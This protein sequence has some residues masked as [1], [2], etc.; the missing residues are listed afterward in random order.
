[1]V[2]F[3]DSFTSFPQIAHRARGQGRRPIN[4]SDNQAASRDSC[5]IG[6]N[7]RLTCSRLVSPSRDPIGHLRGQKSLYEI[8][9]SNLP[10]SLDPTGNF[11]IDVKEASC[12][13][14]G[15]G[16][17]YWGFEDGGVNE[18]FLVQRVCT[19]L[20]V[21]ECKMQAGGCCKPDSPRD[22]NSCV[23]EKLPMKDGRGH[24]LWRLPW[25]IPPGSC[26]TLGVGAITA[27]IR[28]F[29]INIEDTDTWQPAGTADFCDILDINVG[30]HR[31]EPPSYWGKSTG[32]YK[33]CMI[34][35]WNCCTK[36]SPI[37]FLVFGTTGSFPE[38]PACGNGTP[39]K[40][41]GQIPW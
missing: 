41:Q 27:E 28:A 37:G 31:T 16:A 22:C 13:G 40:L 39:P 3:A 19:T 5:S 21:A 14:C 34:H 18:W 4:S 2:T 1:M 9:G 32:T 11:R 12:P 35:G 24:D 29:D 36:A 10:N 26:G 25:S 6:C 33:S 38:Y 30:E 17:V 15:K 23:Y 8:V 7:S 20:S